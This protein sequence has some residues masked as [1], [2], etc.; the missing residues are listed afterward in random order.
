MKVPR[1]RISDHLS[2]SVLAIWK[3]RRRTKWA[4]W[5]FSEAPLSG[6]YRGETCQRLRGF[7]RLSWE[8]DCLG[9]C[10]GNCRAD[11]NLWADFLQ[12]V[13]SLQIACLGGEVAWRWRISR[14]R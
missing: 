7:L 12:H 9:D 10:L 4:K 1:E 11:W 8:I 3:K 2:V 6:E 13:F 14:S 5:I